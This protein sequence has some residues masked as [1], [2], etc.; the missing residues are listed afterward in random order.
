M[1][2][3][4][5]ILFYLLITS[6]IIAQKYDSQWIFGYGT[7]RE[8][9]FGITLLDFNNNI[10]DTSYYG[11]SYHYN[12]GFTGSFI[13]DKNG[14]VVLN[15]NNCD[16]RDADWNIISGDSLI[17]PTGLAAETCT[18]GGDNYGALQSSIFLPDLND[19]NTIYLVHKDFTIDFDAQYTNSDNMWL[20]II[21]KENGE[22]IYKKAI[23]ICERKMIGLRLTSCPNKEK[24]AW[25][26][27]MISNKDTLSIIV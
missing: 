18:N 1:K 3:I 5:L 11:K 27:L 20:S 15:T 6:A 13:N 14:N 7:S 10:V 9:K 4:I 16:I 12:L 22:Y 25:W 21:K 2:K 8:Y 24:N 17:T 26:V 23:R 19:E